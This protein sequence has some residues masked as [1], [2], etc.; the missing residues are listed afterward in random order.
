MLMGINFRLAPRSV[1]PA[2]LHLTSFLFGLRPFL[3]RPRPLT[4]SEPP[5]ILLPFKYHVIMAGGL[6]PAVLHTTS[7][8]LC[9]YISIWCGSYHIKLSLVFKILTVKRKENG[10]K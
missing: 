3:F 1:C 8:A 5:S 4:S 10:L 7:A 9:E 6:D 2:F